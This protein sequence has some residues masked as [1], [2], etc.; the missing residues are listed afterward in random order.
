LTT[1]ASCAF[2]SSSFR[3]CDSSKEYFSMPDPSEVSCARLA[4]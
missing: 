1:W 3:I 2:C 4:A